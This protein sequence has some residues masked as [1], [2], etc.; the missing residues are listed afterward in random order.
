MYYYHG[1]WINFPHS[2]LQNLINGFRN[3][4]SS[5]KIS[6][7]N[8]PL[9]FDYLSMVVI[10]LRTRT[11]LPIAWIDEAEQCYFPTNFNY[12][13]DEN[14]NDW[15]FMSSEKSSLHSLSPYEEIKH[16]VG[17]ITTPSPQKPCNA[18]NILRMKLETLQR[19]SE[20]FTSVQNQFLS[21][22]SPFAK[23]DNIVYI[24]KYVAKDNTSRVREETFERLINL[25]RE[26]R[27]DA[28]VR[29]AWFGAKKMDI[30]GTLIHGFGNYAKPTN[31]NL[32]NGLYLY[33]E[34]RSFASVKFCDVD[35]KGMQ[36]MIICRVI[37]GNVEQL[38]Q[39]SNQYFPTTE[40]FDS[41]VDDILS[42][43]C[44]V[45]WPSNIS[46]YIHP[47]YLISFKLASNVREYLFE[48]NET[49]KVVSDSSSARQV[50][51]MPTKRPTSPWLSFP[52]LFE[53]I[54]EHVSPITMELMLLHFQ[55]LKR[56]VIT[57]EEMV[58]KTRL[59]IGDQMLISSLTKFKREPALWCD[60]P[61]T[62]KRKLD[63]PIANESCTYYAESN[64]H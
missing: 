54:K 20:S 49:T 24:H 30:V 25:T 64:Q 39:G 21:G 1:A 52:A 55:E 16:I 14:S 36:Y 48:L 50:I 62:K 28:N 47:E 8:K 37:L 44:Y 51:Q 31:G 27:G 53:E 29:F 5:I 23:P 59:I 6:I 56:G 11:T 32:G 43:K 63:D 57:R 22:M 4:K 2:I 34:G 60:G 45:V 26:Q 10:N 13:D 58:K 42:P 17:E 38:Q 35:E 19:G 12:D 18:S 15:N 40:N 61:S 7:G 46:S 41:G 9:L 33:P 3:E